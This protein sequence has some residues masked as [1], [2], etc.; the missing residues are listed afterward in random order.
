MFHRVTQGVF[1]RL[2]DQGRFFFAILIAALLSACAL[3]PDYVRPELEL[4]EHYKE[5]AEGW[6][7]ADPA[8]DVLRS[9]WWLAYND[10]ELNQLMNDM[11]AANQSLAQAEARY[12]EA[13]ALLRSSQAAAWPTVGTSASAT[14]SSSGSGRRDLEAR[15]FSTQLVLDG[16]V[17][18]EPDLWGKI[19]RSVESSTAQAE[20]SQAELANTR[21]SLQSMLAQ[22]YFRL[23]GLDEEIAL[24]DKTLQAYQRSLEMTENRYNVGVAPQVD[25]SLAKNQ[26]QNALT[27]KIAL[28]RQR[29][30]IEH[31]IAVL[32]GRAPVNLEIQPAKLKAQLPSIPLGLPSQLLERRP[33]IASAERRTEAANA[34]IGVAQ[35]AWFPDLILNAQAG[36]RGEQLAHWLSA[37]FHFWSLGPRLAL[38]LFD[39]GARQARLDQTR[40]AY[41]AQVAEYRQVVLSALR[42]VE[43][44]LLE[45]HSLGQE[46][47]SQ[48]LALEAARD[49][50]QHTLNQYEAGFIDYLSV[51]QTEASALSAERAAL[52]LH[53]ARLIAS[54]QLIAALGG[55]WEGLLDT[56][57]DSVN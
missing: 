32:L 23:R 52:S 55:G 44:Y 41:D 40:A 38:T 53:A 36:Y 19:R 50:L 8:D 1:R 42:E 28:E 29:A 7:L 25:V 10:A 3:G 21:L 31:A 30:Q 14:R 6:V 39:G 47:E 49:A 33:D 37:P 57:L 51:V 45:V 56:E 34:Q 4:G 11:L 43:D 2:I 46:A 35:A 9:D 12:R 54:V 26:Y 13:L 22:N 18:W 27:Q 5:A 16:S 20:A 48:A 15:S 24:Y 17:S